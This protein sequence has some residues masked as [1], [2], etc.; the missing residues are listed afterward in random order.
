[1]NKPCKPLHHGRRIKIHP[2]TV[3][4]FLYSYAFLLIIPILQ[5]VLFRPQDIGEMLRTSSANVLLAAAV[6]LYAYLRYKR[7]SIIVS[8]G[9]I[10]VSKGVFRRRKNIIYAKHVVAAA[11]RQGAVTSFFGA[12][13]LCVGTGGNRLIA[14]EYIKKKS[15]SLPLFDVEGKTERLSFFHSLVAAADATSALSGLLLIIPFLRKTAPVVGE[16]LSEGFYGGI[17]LWSHL[18]SKLLPPAVAYVSG[19]IAAGYGFAF[20]YELLKHIKIQITQ[21]KEYMKISR[22][23][24]WRVVT[25]QPKE[26]MSALTAEQGLLCMVLGIKKLF[27]L[28]HINK[29]LG[30]ERELVGVERGRIK[31]PD[32]VSVIKPKRRS[33]FSFVLAPLLLLVLSVA[34]ALYFEQIG[35]IVTVSVV[36]SVAVPFLLLW[37]M[38]RAAAFEHSFIKKENDCVLACSY[39]GLR[40]VQMKVDND[41]INAIEIR[42]NPFQKIFGS[43]NVRIYAHNRRKPFTVKKLKA[44]TEF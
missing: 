1:M 24:I 32:D 39:S 37:T 35:R 8:N 19:L 25:V 41:K 33:V 28:S 31:R 30:T 22:G 13:T 18:A 9:R 17:N 40:L 21:N 43:C 12:Q 42:Q 3:A 14:E 27:V 26:E 23:V 2:V 10:T 4:A 38:F 7:T 5:F 34:G 20:V 36:M 11:L 6:V 44:V 15:G 16:G 29:S